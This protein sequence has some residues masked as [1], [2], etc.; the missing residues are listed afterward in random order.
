MVWPF[1]VAL[2][3]EFLNGVDLFSLF[4]EKGYPEDPWFTPR[5]GPWARDDPK[6]DVQAA[7]ILF[8][9]TCGLLS[10]CLCCCCCGACCLGGFVIRKKKPHAVKH[11]YSFFGLKSTDE[12]ALMTLAGVAMNEAPRATK[13]DLENGA[14]YGRFIN[15]VKT[16]VKKVKD[17]GIDEAQSYTHFKSL[18]HC[19]EFRRLVESYKPSTFC[20]LYGHCDRIL[21]G[22]GSSHKKN[23][24]KV[25]YQKRE[26]GT[27][28][29][30]YLTDVDMAL[31]QLRNSG[32]PI[33]SEA[34]GHAA[35]MNAGI[36]QNKIDLI[37]VSMKGEDIQFEEVFETLM[38]ICPEHREVVETNQVTVSTDALFMQKQRL[39]WRCGSSKHMAYDPV[40]KRGPECAKIEGL[41]LKPTN[42]GPKKKGGHADNPTLLCPEVP[43]A[44]GAGDGKSG[45]GM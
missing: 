1:I 36:D 35:I 2:M 23:L 9:I 40:D 33:S 39:C 6:V 21:G 15:G 43:P 24:E 26:K 42:L 20:E 37:R 13:D 10:T 17:L 16:W 22:R 18:D 41:P 7:I 11:A 14:T 5:Y 29:S 28:I 32:S 45:Q 19:A 30:E 25:L 31:N 38:K 34:A 44:A 27:S 4:Q 12:N 8:F 3:S